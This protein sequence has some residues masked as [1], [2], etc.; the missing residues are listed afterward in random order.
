M[1]MRPASLEELVPDDHDVRTVWAVVQS[2]DLSGFLDV[3]RSPGIGDR[4]I[5]RLR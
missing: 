1:V 3:L 4:T 2:W 5:V